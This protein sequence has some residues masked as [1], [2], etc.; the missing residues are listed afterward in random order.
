MGIKGL[1]QAIFKSSR[2]ATKSPRSLEPADK[3]HLKSLT[4][5]DS[6]S[7]EELSNKKM[8]VPNRERRSRKH[9]LR[10]AD[11]WQQYSQLEVQLHALKRHSK[12]YKCQTSLRGEQSP[13]QVESTALV[14]LSQRRS[15]Q[16]LQQ[17][18]TSLQNKQPRNSFQN[19]TIEAIRQSESN[20]R[21]NTARPSTFRG[22]AASV[23][24]NGKNSPRKTPRRHTEGETIK[25]IWK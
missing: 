22:R 10:L 21:S 14:R 4:S 6:C 25:K 17:T 3:K 1:I 20:T 24:S 5:Q 16:Q 2:D 9:T 18:I 19:V 15:E 13:R 11:L 23:I 7:W 8:M 12:R